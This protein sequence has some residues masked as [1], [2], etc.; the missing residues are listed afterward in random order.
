MGLKYVSEAIPSGYGN[1]GRG[2]LS[3]LVAIG[4][5]VVWAPMIV[6]TGWNRYLQ[7]HPGAM[8]DDEFRHLCGR[9]VDYDSVVVHLI[10]RYFEPWRRAEPGKKLIGM[11][12]WETDQLPE[13]TL[14]QLKGTDALV[15]PCRWN[16]HTY[17]R[18]GF[19][20]PIHVAPHVPVPSAGEPDKMKLPG[21]GP[22]DFVAIPGRS[23]T[24]ITEPA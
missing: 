16:A 3:A 14:A 2:Y 11:T 12:V 19:P 17:R 8:I 7:P 24:S 10:P 1:A 18:C 21:V 4:A 9:S 5:D 6:G 20:G 13:G 22:D 23:Q 15:V